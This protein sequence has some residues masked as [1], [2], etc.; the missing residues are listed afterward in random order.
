[1]VM[2]NKLG[3]GQPDDFFMRSLWPHP[4]PLE[5]SLSELQEVGHEL[6]ATS[7]DRS[8][9]SAGLICRRQVFIIHDETQL[10]LDTLRKTKVLRCN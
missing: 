4:G 10:N 5:T 7:G 8:F 1:M 9:G 3:A 6:A 2:G